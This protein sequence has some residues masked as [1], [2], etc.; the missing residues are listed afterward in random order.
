MRPFAAVLVAGALAAAG[1]ASASTFVAAVNSGTTDL[2]VFAAGQYNI[3]ATGIASLVGGVGSGFDIRPDGV[4]NTPVTNP[5]YAASFNPNGTDMA[6]GI[7]GAGGAGIKL[8][9]LMGSFVA[10]APLG[11]NHA[12]LSNYFFIGYGTTI[13]HAGGHLYAQVNDT[14][15]SNDAGGFD[16]TVR[17]VVTGGVP[18]PATW[19]MMLL[20]FFAVGSALRRGAGQPRLA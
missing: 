17:Q 3:T 18:E 15:Y 5:A 4:P 13:T 11:N 10:V 19:A 16:V 14:F 1:S 8:G 7:Y 9:A 6:D 12:P 20:G 2:G